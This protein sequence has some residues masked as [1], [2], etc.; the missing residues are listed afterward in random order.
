MSVGLS[1]PLLALIAA[2]VSL[3]AC[4]T[5]TRVAAP[6]LALREGQGAWFV[7]VLLAM[8]AVAPV[9]LALYAG[10]LADRFGYHRPI[11]IAVALALVGG[12]GP[13]HTKKAPA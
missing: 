11:Y 7:G 2:Q 8:F 3:H 9:V 12:R 13:V 1:R 4:M 5:G 6:L 10:R